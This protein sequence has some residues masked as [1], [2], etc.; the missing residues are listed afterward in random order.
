MQCRIYPAWHSIFHVE[1]YRF[2]P[3]MLHQVEKY[4]RAH[5]GGFFANILLPL[6]KYLMEDTCRKHLGQTYFNGSWPRI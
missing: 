4:H 1:D 2:E 3:G 5:D 6:N